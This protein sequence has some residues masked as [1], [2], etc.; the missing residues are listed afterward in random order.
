M[1][2]PHLPLQELPE[3]WILSSCGK[4]LTLALATAGHT[5]CPAL[6]DSSV[7]VRRSNYGRG[8]QPLLVRISSLFSTL[9]ELSC[10]IPSDSPTS[11]HSALQRGFEH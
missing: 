3:A 4:D 9:N 10:P 7:L 1:A 6:L 5:H 11:S 8:R 2:G